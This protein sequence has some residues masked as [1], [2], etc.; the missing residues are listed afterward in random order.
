M[1]SRGYVTVRE[2]VMG[3]WGREGGKDGKVSDS[4]VKRMTNNLC[5]KRRDNKEHPIT[6]ILDDKEPLD[7]K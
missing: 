3:V 4:L 1:T 5:S 7:P 2:K 6:S